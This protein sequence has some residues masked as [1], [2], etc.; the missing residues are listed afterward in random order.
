MDKLK[1]LNDHQLPFAKILGLKYT[2]ASVINPFEMRYST[3]RRDSHLLERYARDRDAIFTL[4]QA[5]KEL[6][7]RDVL[8]QV[9]RNDILG[10]RA[11]LL[12]VTFKLIPSLRFVGEV[13]AANKRL[14]DAHVKAIPQSS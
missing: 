5:F 3:I 9:A 2:A 4:E 8:M 13:K 11:K 6:K 12:D 1:F 7:E 10:D 14:H